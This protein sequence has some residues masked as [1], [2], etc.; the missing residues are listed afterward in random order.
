MKCLICGKKLKNNQRKYCSKKCRLKGL[1]TLSVG[2]KELITEDLITKLANMIRAGVTI[3]D[4]CQAIGINESTYY[5]WRKRA[6]AEPKSLYF[7]LIQSIERAQAEAKISIIL[8]WRK[9]L[10]GDWRACEAFLKRRYP[11]EWGDRIKHEGEME[12]KVDVGDKV[13][14]LLQD[15]EKYKTINEFVLELGGEEFF[16]EEDSTDKS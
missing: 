12:V 6:E 13:K 8:E 5:K 2:R 10:S 4:A 9:L 11:E 16:T 14:K 1:H 15:P 7:K 3:K